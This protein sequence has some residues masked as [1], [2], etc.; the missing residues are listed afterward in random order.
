M[1]LRPQ[2]YPSPP[3]LMH[4]CQKGAQCILW[5]VSGQSLRQSA[6]SKCR[7]SH[8]LPGR[9]RGWHEFPWTYTTSFG[10]I[11]PRTGKGQG[12]EKEE[13]EKVAPL[14]P[15]PFSHCLTCLT[16]IIEKKLI[17]LFVEVRGLSWYSKLGPYR[18][19]IK[20]ER[21]LVF[22][23]KYCSFS[24][25]QVNKWRQNELSILSPCFSPLQLFQLSL[26]LK[27]FTMECLSQT[28]L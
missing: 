21:M 10:H 24:H 20:E 4:M 1:S 18:K 19:S 3:S 17:I 15:D 16:P 6:G 2:S 22:F 14:P 8:L 9:L 11:S 28:N 12:V 27:Q 5:C 13:G 26:F 7:F 25:V 23:T